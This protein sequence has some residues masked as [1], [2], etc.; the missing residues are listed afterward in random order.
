MWF[1]EKYGGRIDRQA[2]GRTAGPTIPNLYLQPSTQRENE[3]VDICTS[4]P[5]VRRKD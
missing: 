4:C 5:K 2:E 3:N 1:K